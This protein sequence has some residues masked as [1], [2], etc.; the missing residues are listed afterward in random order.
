M[1]Q[2]LNGHLAGWHLLSQ[3]QGG[4][5]FQRLRLNIIRQKGNKKPTR[6]IRGKAMAKTTRW[7]DGISPSE[8]SRYMGNSAL[9]E[10]Q[11]SFYRSVWAVSFVWNNK[12]DWPW[13]VDENGRWCLGL[14]VVSYCLWNVPW[15]V[16]HAGCYIYPLGRSFRIQSEWICLVCVSKIFIFFPGLRSSLLDWKEASLLTGRQINHTIG[17]GCLYR[18]GVK[19]GCT[20]LLHLQT[21]KRRGGN[22]VRLA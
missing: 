21:K 2:K 4:V 15:V 14:M 22:C 9:S 20:T 3:L 1:V 6:T 8:G 12:F 5:Q 13:M 19:T 16:L 7:C 17:C 18:V 11:R 10:S